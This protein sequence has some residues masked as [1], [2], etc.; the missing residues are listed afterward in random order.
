VLALLGAESA[1][2]VESVSNATVAE[3]SFEAVSAALLRAASQN[4][5]SAAIDTTRIVAP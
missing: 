3:G 5:G 4:D 1:T 2:S